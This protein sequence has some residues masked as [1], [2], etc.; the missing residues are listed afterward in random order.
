MDA[1][2]K[3]VV[4]DHVAYLE[5]FIGNQVVRRDKRVRLLPGKILTLPLHSQIR[6]CQF[7]SGF[8]AVLALLLFLRHAA[9]RSSIH[10]RR[11]LLRMN[12]AMRI[13]SSRAVY[14]AFFPS[15]LYS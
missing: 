9:P 1:L 11:H 5:M 4:L 8:L 6:L 15:N 10:K 14:C 12:C 3:C 7:L 13:A 2:G